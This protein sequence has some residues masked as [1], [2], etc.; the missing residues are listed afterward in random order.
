MRWFLHLACAALLI[1]A[2]GAI[3]SNAT[4]ASLERLVMPGP[5][6]SAHAE[7]EDECGSCHAPQADTPQLQL[8]VVC[9]ENVGEDLMN[10][11]GLH[12]LH[13]D[14]ADN[15]CQI[16]HAEH[17]GRDAVGLKFDMSSFDHSLTDF[18]LLWSHGLTACET[19][20]T[21]EAEFHEVA[22]TCVGCH[23]AE[24][25]HDG[26]LGTQCADCHSQRNWESNHFDHATTGFLLSGA[27]SQLQCADCH[28]ANSFSGVQS[29]CVSCH[30]PDD[31]HG[32]SLGTACQQCHTTDTWSGSGFDHA[33]TGFALT[34]QHLELT[35]ES[36]HQSGEAMSAL[37]SSCAGCHATDDVHEGRNGTECASC[38]STALWSDVSFDHFQRSGFALNGAHELLTCTNC[39]VSSVTQSLAQTCGECHVDDDPHQQQLGNSCE[40][41]HNETAWDTAIR[42]D[43]DL[44]SFP[45]LGGHAT[46][47][48]SACHSSGRFLDAP[49]SCG[50][51]HAEDDVHQGSLGEQCSGCHNPSAWRATVFDHQT[52]SGFPLAGAHERLSCISCHG[53]QSFLQAASADDC[54]V[55]HR[56]DDPHNG[57]FSSDC[58]RCHS[59]ES[60]Q[61]LRG[62]N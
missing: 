38:H 57:R 19:C 52:A 40:S 51:C 56:Q 60:F 35:C 24:D 47:D 2:G 55:C 44:V 26:G 30:Q 3:S 39:H 12:G 13:P 49:G 5:V 48:C 7:L 58:A 18:P 45:L 50:E 54:A 16:C 23:A 20:H 31:V 33:T 27:H 42:F 59:L 36:C 29:D 22:N 6:S 37:D 32:G 8:C 62:L 10:G 15:E 11:T 4:A 43:H 17:E 41:C 61:I 21:P 34:G 14:V 53:K 28:P 9:H 46:L 1:I 25:P